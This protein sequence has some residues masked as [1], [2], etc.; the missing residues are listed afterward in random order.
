M[1]LSK[2]ISRIKNMTNLQLKIKLGLV[3]YWMEIAN[4]IKDPIARQKYIKRME[5]ERQ[6]NSVRTL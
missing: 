2:E 3:P 4:K 1:V 5:R 6:N